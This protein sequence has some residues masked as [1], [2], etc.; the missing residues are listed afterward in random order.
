MDEVNKLETLRR[1]GW[2]RFSLKI[3]M[4]SRQ[5]P[6]ELQSRQREIVIQLFWRWREMEFSTAQAMKKLSKARNS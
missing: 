5:V 6:V 3:S 4:S 2:M 1:G